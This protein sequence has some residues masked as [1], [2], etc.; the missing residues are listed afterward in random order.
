MHKI[1]I[2]KIINSNDNKKMEDL[3]DVLEDTIFYIKDV[4]EDT[5]NKIEC[6]LYEIA[7]GKVLDGNMAKEWVNKMQPKAKWSL[8]EIEQL[9][10]Q[11]QFNL[12]IISAYVI[13]NMLYSD[14]GDVLGEEM[15]NETLQRYIQMAEDWYY[16]SDAK[17]TE[18]EKLYC[19][20]KSIIN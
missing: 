1:Y 11:Y 19:Y 12:P 5:Y 8:N 13:M 6:D 14:F 20:W 2:D 16:D 18:D 17:H 4:D 3:R 7:M 15:N 9:K 10:N